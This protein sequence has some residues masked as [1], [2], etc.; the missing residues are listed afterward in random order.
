MITVWGEQK[1]FKTLTPFEFD[2]MRMI[3]NPFYTVCGNFVFP[4]VINTN[5]LPI[6]VTFLMKKKILDLK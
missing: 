2:T 6:I 5:G 4:E 1:V 3:L